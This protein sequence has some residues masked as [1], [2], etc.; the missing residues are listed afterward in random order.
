MIVAFF[1][2]NIM[3]KCVRATGLVK[4]GFVF[5]I[6]IGLRRTAPSAQTLRPVVPEKVVMKELVVVPLG[7]Q[8]TIATL[9]AL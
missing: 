1:V 6:N 8:A 5:A 3:D 7:F 9:M 4:L 2:P